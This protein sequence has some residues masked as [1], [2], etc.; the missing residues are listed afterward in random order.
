VLKLALE[1]VWEEVLAVMVNVFVILDTPVKIVL[2]SK[3]F[4]YL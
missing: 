1:V 4:Y 2:D 3:F